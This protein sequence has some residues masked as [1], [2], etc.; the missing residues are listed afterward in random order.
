[1]L[2]KQLPNCKITYDLAGTDNIETTFKKISDINFSAN[3]YPDRAGEELI[4][5]ISKV[6][7]ADGNAKIKLRG[8][9]NNEAERKTVDAYIQNTINSI[10]GKGISSY[11]AN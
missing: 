5:K 1:M 4:T 6:L 3:Y 11:P 7:R 8:G 2:E 10:V 9:Y